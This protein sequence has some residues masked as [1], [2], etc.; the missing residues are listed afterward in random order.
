M[1]E[2]KLSINFAGKDKEVI[3]FFQ[4]CHLKHIYV[5]WKQTQMER[6][7]SEILSF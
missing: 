6:L 5:D 4:D 3:G 2:K 7:L 1:T